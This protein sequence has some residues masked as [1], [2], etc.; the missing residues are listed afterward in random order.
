MAT[1]DPG[2]SRPAG[3]GRGS[4]D[5]I[6]PRTATAQAEVA[7]TLLVSEIFWPVKGGSARWFDEV[8]RRYPPGK[9][10]VLTVPSPDRP[11]ND[12]R[13]HLRVYRR[14][15]RWRPRLKP[16]DF[17]EIAGTMGFHALRLVRRNRYGMI[18]CGRIFPEG[19]AGWFVNRVLGLP[20]VIY[21]HGEEVSR[22]LNYR[23]ERR[24]LPVLFGRAAAVIA[25]S[26]NS[27]A[28]ARSGGADPD[29][30]EVI[31]PG[32]D[33]EVFHDRADG[34]RTRSRFGLGSARVLLTVGRLTR[35][36]GQAQVIRCLPS[37]R[38]DLG[39][40]RYLMIGTGEDR[41][42]LEQLAAEQGVQDSVVFGGRADDEQ[43]PDVYAACDL[44]VMPT[45]PL[46]DG[47]LEGFGMVYLEAGASGKAVI[48]GRCGGVAESIVDGRTGLLV[49][50]ARHDELAG[51]ITRLLRDPD[52]ARRLGQAGRERA[53]SQFGWDEITRRTHRLALS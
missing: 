21:V 16:L 27:A 50:A 3:A 28:L 42:M 48:G 1:E 9:A 2:T 33:P 39:D 14:W 46:S 36:K 23:I 13:R 7:R 10:G 49:D 44:F 41:H 30:V 17:L 4:A 45:V 38:R 8:Y 37:L 52:E 51:A 40:V 31:H 19:F 22:Y 43:L 24:I 18:H 35:R 11:R 6:A 25:N 53:I 29:V 12:R 34:C 5:A 47:D 32:V 26:H 15:M 20:Y